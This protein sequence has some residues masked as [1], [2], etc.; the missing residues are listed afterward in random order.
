MP[1]AVYNFRIDK[2]DIRQKQE[3]GSEPYLNI[4]LKCID[5]GEHL[6][7][8]VFDIVTLKK[9]ATFKLRQLLED[10]L[11]WS[12]DDELSETEQLVGEEVAAA[13]TTEKGRAGYSD[14]NKVVRYMRKP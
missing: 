5:D 2:I 7:R 10:G 13:I 3:A 1:D 14:R 8:A 9:G 6:G 11:G 4:M 12:E